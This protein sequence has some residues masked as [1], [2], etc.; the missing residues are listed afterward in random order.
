MSEK[1]YVVSEAEL[2]AL[3]CAAVE[4]GEDDSEDSFIWSHLQTTKTTCRARPVERPHNGKNSILWI[5]CEKE[6]V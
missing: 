5:E 3:K 4:W 6:D 2:D 1:Y